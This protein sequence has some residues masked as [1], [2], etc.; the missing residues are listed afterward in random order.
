LEEINGAK[1]TKEKVRIQVDILTVEENWALD[2]E[3]LTSKLN[4]EVKYKRFND[5]TYDMVN[6]P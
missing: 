3:M 1:Y 4:F 2:R 6:S 5:S